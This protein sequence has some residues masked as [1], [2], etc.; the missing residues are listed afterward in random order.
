MPIAS[1]ALALALRGVTRRFGEVT[2]VDGLELE[3]GH[4]QVLGVLGPN[5][6]GKSTTLR[7]IL[8]LLVPSAGTVEVLG[9]T[10]DLEVRRH[11]GYLPEQRG[12]YDEMRV[13]DQVAWFG[14]LHGLSRAEAWDRAGAWLDR[15]GLG[16]RTEARLSELSKGMQQRVQLAVALVHAPPLL[17]LDEPFSGLDPVSQDVFAEVV[18]EEKARGASILLCT[19]E[20]AHAERAC[21]RVVVLMAGRKELEGHVRHLRREAATGRV[22][23]AFEGGDD[24]LD[25]PQVLARERVDDGWEIQLAEGVPER[26]VL[27]E[28][29]ARG[30]VPERFARAEPSLHEIV[31]ARIKGDWSDRDGEEAA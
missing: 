5:G 4:G 8:G 22:R 20:I 25:A 23:L 11:V 17:V 2:A 24:W 3:L 7:M 31:V 28:A 29:L 30:I 15:L 1:S 13:R 6:S 14:E 19:H 10:P 9:R 26:W 18:A 27:D 12:L 21:D 16:E